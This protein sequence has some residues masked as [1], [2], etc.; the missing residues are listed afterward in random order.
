MK[1]AARGGRR[2]REGAERYDLQSGYIELPARPLRLQQAFAAF[3][4]SHAIGVSR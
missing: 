4:A 1:T 2:P 3:D